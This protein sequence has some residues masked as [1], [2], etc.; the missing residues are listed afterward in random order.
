M[1]YL[2]FQFFLCDTEM[3]WGKREMS[4]KKRSL[5]DIYIPLA[6]PPVFLYREL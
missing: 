3:S 2:I 6:L 4:D 5:Y 1:K